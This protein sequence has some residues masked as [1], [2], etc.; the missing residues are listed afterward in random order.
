MCGGGRRWIEERL[1]W[2]HSISS[3]D[4]CYRARHPQGAAASGMLLRP[5]VRKRKSHAGKV[6]VIDRGPHAA[7]PKCQSTPCDESEDGPS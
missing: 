5:H 1:A 3:R 6:V 7:L 4:R 2:Y